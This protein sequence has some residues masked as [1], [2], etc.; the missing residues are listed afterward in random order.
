MDL[1]VLV[2]QIIADIVPQNGSKEC[3]DP[4]QINTNTDQ[5]KVH[6][7]ISNWN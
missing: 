4:D 7:R 3:Y 6:L 2:L 1:L 5:Q